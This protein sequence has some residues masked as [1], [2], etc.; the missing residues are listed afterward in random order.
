MFIVTQD[1]RIAVNVDQQTKI[2]CSADR[3]YAIAAFDG[4]NSPVTLATF[5]NKRTRDAV[6]MHLM[7]EGFDHAGGAIFMPDDDAENVNGFVNGD[8]WHIKGESPDEE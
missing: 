7:I 4:C 6:F 5:G 2:F 8:I 3:P 1:R